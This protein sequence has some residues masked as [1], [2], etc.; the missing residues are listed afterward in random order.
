VQSI[1]AQ[2]DCGKKQVFAAQNELFCVRDDF[3]NAV[4][5]R[6]KYLNRHPAIAGAA[7]DLSPKLEAK[8]IVT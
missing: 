5:G 7:S 1:L 6:G 3:G 2:R 4:G 8:Q